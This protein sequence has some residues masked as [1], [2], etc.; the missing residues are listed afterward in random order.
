M[1]EFDPIKSKSNRQKHGIDFVEA[2]DL[3]D[4]PGV[5]REAT[6]SGELRWLLI[7]KYGG[8]IWAGIYT[9]RG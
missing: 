5:I 4:V 8:K 6:F 7:A 1:S 9:M 3:W 2:R